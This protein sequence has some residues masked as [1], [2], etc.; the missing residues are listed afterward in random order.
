MKTK[1]ELRK[2][3][4]FVAKELSQS[5]KPRTWY[6]LAECLEKPYPYT[7]KSKYQFILQ[8]LTK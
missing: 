1:S 5:V 6:L 7:L 4:E 3:Q 2:L 8:L